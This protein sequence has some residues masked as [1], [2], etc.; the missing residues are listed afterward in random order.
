MG[1]HKNH[2]SLRQKPC[3]SVLGYLCNDGP[4]W[5]PPV[6]DTGRFSGTEA[7]GYSSLGYAGLGRAQGGSG[8]GE[9]ERPRQQI[10]R[11]EVTLTVHED[12]GIWRQILN[13][14]LAAGT[15][16]EAALRMSGW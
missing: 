1:S 14:D 7:A 8:L 12:D 6:R 13:H 11:A 4:S 15:A 2:E 9:S 5:S 10:G 3:Q 16:R